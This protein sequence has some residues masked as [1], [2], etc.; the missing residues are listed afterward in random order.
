MQ[1][2]RAI[3][4]FSVA[5]LTCAFVGGLLWV[6]FL[7]LKHDFQQSIDDLAKRHFEATG[8]I[9]RV[10]QYFD[11]FD[12]WPAK[13]IVES[14]GAPWFP[15]DWVYDA[16]SDGAAIG[17]NG[18]Y[19]TILSYRFAPPFAGAVNATW[20]LNIEGDVREFGAATVYNPFSRDGPAKAK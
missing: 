9:D 3:R 2:K 12:R 14:P 4:R 8:G 16:D 1:W 15:A 17:L 7:R 13:S 10:Y 6:A 5:T 20:R 19:H 18:P 11:R